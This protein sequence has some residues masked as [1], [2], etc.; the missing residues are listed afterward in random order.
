MLVWERGVGPTAA[1][2]SGACSIGKFIFSQGFT[3][4]ESWLEVSMPGGNLYTKSE[5][6]EM[7][8]AGKCQKV[9]SGSIEI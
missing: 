8:L 6:E 1:C 3:E 4:E 9:F 5:E 7:L 2:G